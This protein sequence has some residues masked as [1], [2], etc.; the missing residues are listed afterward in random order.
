MKMI[1][2]VSLQLPVCV[3]VS[4]SGISAQDMGGWRSLVKNFL[5]PQLLVLIIDA[6][7]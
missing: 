1:I 3:C 7:G 4:S 6:E 2:I 5:N